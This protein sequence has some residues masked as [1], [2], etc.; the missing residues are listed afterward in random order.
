MARP[1]TDIRPRL[2]HAARDRFLTQGV[3]GASLRE[4]AAKAGTS[5]GMVYYYFPTKD[6]LFFAVVEEVYQQ[7]LGD[8]EAS[9]A[10]GP[11]VRERLRALFRR[12]AA[13]SAEELDVV[14]LV[15]REA[16][17]SSA[18]RERLLE[19]FMRGHLPLVLR[20]LDEGVREG[21]LDPGRPL[22]LLLIATFA[23][24]G[25]PQLIMRQVGAKLGAGLLP[26]G[27]ALA[28]LL[29]DVL[30]RGIGKPGG[31]GGGGREAVARAGGPARAGA[32]KRRSRKKAAKP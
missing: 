24:A 22:P 9:L 12:I 3:D 27:E 18:R 25:P 28:D 26:S 31:E 23:L 21:L 29:L 10:T 11:A 5:I 32:G 8:L 4:I 16:L 20:L 30:L 19:R 1:A 15:V 7:L 14:R 6:D 2:V 13:L 17:V